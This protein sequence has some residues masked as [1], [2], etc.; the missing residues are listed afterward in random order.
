MRIPGTTFSDVPIYNPKD[1]RIQA[2]EDAVRKHRDEKGDNR[3]Y[4]DDYEL[5]KV[6]GEPIPETACQLD[7]PDV[8]L[9]NCQR[10]IQCRHDP[11]KQYRS[12]MHAIEELIVTNEK[13]DETITQL[14]FEI[15]KLKT[16]YQ[17]LKRMKEMEFSQSCLDELDR[18]RGWVADL[19]IENIDLKQRYQTIVNLHGGPK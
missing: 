4:L 8:M 2:L 18:L 1:L 7:E 6:L 16:E 5:Y 9:T 10:F 11:N 19:K 13:K 12:P 15:T 3:C 17:K 14:Q